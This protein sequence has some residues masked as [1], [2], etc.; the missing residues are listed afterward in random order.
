MQRVYIEKRTEEVRQKFE[1]MKNCLDERSRRIWAAT[2]AKGIGYGGQSIVS[3]A[4]GISRTTILSAIKNTE[5]K[6]T[7]SPQQRIRG[8]GGGRKS[9]KKTD[10]TLVKDL[11][12]LVEPTTRGDRSHHCAGPAKAQGNLQ[13][14]S[15][16]KG[17]R[18]NVRQ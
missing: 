14:R 13:E 3:K 8:T 10:R 2:E 15:K 12:A 1:V 9:L 4:T 17:T 11:E 16:S 18:L 7:S 5:K 6:K